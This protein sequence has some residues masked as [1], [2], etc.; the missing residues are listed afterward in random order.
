MGFLALRDI[1]DGE[2]MCYDYGLRTDEVWTRKGRL[3]DGKVTCGNDRVGVEATA[4]VKGSGDI[5]VGGAEASA[6]NPGGA[7][8]TATIS[9]V[10]EAASVVPKKVK[11]KSYWCPIVGYT[12]GPVQKITQH[13][14]IVHHIPIGSKLSILLRKHN[15]LAPREAILKLI[16]NPYAR[17]RLGSSHTLTEY[18][19]KAGPSRSILRYA[20]VS[21]EVMVGS[22]GGEKGKGMEA[23]SG[24]GGFKCGSGK[25]KGKAAGSGGGKA[26]GFKSGG[27]S[28]T[29]KRVSETGGNKTEHRSTP[30]L[31]E[32]ESGGGEG[33]TFSEPE[34]EGGW[35]DGEEFLKRCSDFLQSPLGGSKKEGAARQ[36]VTNA[37]RMRINNC[38]RGCDN[39]FPIN[40]P[41]MRQQLR[42][43]LGFAL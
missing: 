40:Q 26:K 16:P 29:V 5:E 41:C 12:S 17:Y 23:G 35:V 15:R 8:A 7:V 38:T 10:S 31:D 4:E 25:G 2:E 34:L 3:V 42:L 18:M 39:Y 36:L 37:V 13:C 27:S 6:S 14:K 28:S 21:A 9:G 1:D 20:P 30:T 19:P 22:N 32:S 43:R 33:G 24:S 11:H